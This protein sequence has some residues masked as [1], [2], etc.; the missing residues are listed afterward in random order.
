MEKLLQKV[1]LPCKRSA[2]NFQWPRIQV[3]PDADFSQELGGGRIDRESWLKGNATTSSHSIAAPSPPYSNTNTPL[4]DLAPSDDEEIGTLRL[5][6]NFKEMNLNPN[7]HRGTHFFGKSSGVM[8]IQK[9]IVLKK[10]ATGSDDFNVHFF[11]ELEKERFPVRQHR[12][13]KITCNM[14]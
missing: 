13:F 14:F 3:C 5:S 1:R 6:E 9:A 10:E 4:E 7:P 2:L 12:S 11:R 8:L